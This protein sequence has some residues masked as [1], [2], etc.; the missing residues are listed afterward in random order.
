MNL[1]AANYDAIMREYDNQ[2]LENMRALNKRTQEIYEK[3]P[4]IRQIDEQISDLAG[5]Y[6]AAFTTE[7]AMTF[8]QYRK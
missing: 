5:E 1:S 3:F 4:Q 8:S 6:A 7:G 2:R